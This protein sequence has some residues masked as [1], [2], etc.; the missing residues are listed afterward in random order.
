MNININNDQAAMN[1][2]AHIYLS[3][4]NDDIKIGNFIGD[5]VKG[6]KYLQYR[7]NIRKGIILHRN[8]DD[9]TDKSKIP[10]PVKNLLKPFYRRYAGIVV[11]VLY[12]HCLSKNWEYFCQTPLE[13]YVNNFHKLLRREFSVLPRQVQNFVPRMI[14]HNRLLSYRETTG[15]HQSLTVMAKHT[16]LPDKADQAIDVLLKNY[17]T[18]NDNFLEFFPMLI[19]YV[20]KVH[21]ID[22]QY[23]FNSQT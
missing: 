21:S 13:E 5:Y 22:I 11:D 20:K 23:N 18:I 17:S 2:L 16:S 4:T 15:L 8:I 10:Q 19:K 6:R 3:G 12:D 9:Y 14:Q 7:T 1:F